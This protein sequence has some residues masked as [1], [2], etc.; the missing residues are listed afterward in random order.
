MTMI[1]ASGDRHPA[2]LTFATGDVIRKEGLS[3]VETRT[4]VKRIRATPLASMCSVSSKSIR[5]LKIDKAPAKLLKAYVLKDRKHFRAKITKL[6]D[7]HLKDFLHPH[8][9]AELDHL[10]SADKA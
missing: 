6:R 10:R 1:D 3:T 7:F 4:S 2:S 8:S 9:I 5:A